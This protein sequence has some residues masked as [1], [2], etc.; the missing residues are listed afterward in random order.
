MYYLLFMESNDKYAKFL[1]WLKINGS[2]LDS[3]EFPVEFSNIIGVSSKFDIG[4][5]EAIFYIPK[6][7]IIDSNYVKLFELNEFYL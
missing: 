3:T 1:N 5:N 4:P 7:I 2:I 6:K